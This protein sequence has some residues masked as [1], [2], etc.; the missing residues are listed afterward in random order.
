MPGLPWISFR[1]LLVAGF[2]YANPG[3]INLQQV[4]GSTAMFKITVK[5]IYRPREVREI[6]G[7][8]LLPV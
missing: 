5:A 4:Q 7:E 1:S 3:K 6:Y 2:Q 8:L